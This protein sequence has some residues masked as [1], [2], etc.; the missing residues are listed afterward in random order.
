MKGRGLNHLSMGAFGE[1]EGGF[2]PP[3]FS[4][5]GWR[6]NHF[7]TPQWC[8]TQGLNLE[9]PD[10]WC[11]KQVLPLHLL[12]AQSVLLL[13]YSDKSGALT[14]WA[15][16]AYFIRL[17][18]PPSIPNQFMMPYVIDNQWALVALVGLEPTPRIEY[19]FWI[20][21]INQFCYRAIASGSFFTVMPS[22]IG[23]LFGD[24]YHPALWIPRAIEFET[25]NH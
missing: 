20:R 22:T 17:S 10:Y 13:H 15:S 14:N 24:C 4:S 6:D 18:E 23:I 8:S 9:P 3:I 12:N 5:W 1:R 2:E 25:A 7:S 21:C 11:L 16:G 19:G